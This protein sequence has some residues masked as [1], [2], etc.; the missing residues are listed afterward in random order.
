MRS[1]TPDINLI[2]ERLK[3]IDYALISYFLKVW[4]EKK[5]ISVSRREEKIS[6]SKIKL[7]VTLIIYD[8]LRHLNW[9]RAHFMD[10]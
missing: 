6:K 10:F 7:L 2:V 5:K 1:F 9:Q 3:L 8:N 4:I